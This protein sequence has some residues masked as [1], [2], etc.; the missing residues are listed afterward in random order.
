MPK[1]IGSPTTV[2]CVGNMSKYADE[3]V[4]LVNTGNAKV[5]ITVVHSP[6]GWVGVGQYTDYHEYRIVLKGLLQVEH[7]EGTMDVEPGQA[8]DIPPEEWVRYS[9]PGDGGAD[10]VTVCTP[11]FSRAG[12]HRDE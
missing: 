1:L 8:L 7:A 2:A 12:V 4:G 5:S 3:Y 9:T 11:A 10:Y 6:A